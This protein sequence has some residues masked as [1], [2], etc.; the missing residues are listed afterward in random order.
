MSSNALDLFLLP[1]F[2]GL[3]IGFMAIAAAW[4]LLTSATRLWRQAVDHD[5]ELWTEPATI[6]PPSLALSGE[7]NT[8][9]A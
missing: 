5:H 2:E 6:C 4:T 3:G 8:K 7:R 9:H 1:L